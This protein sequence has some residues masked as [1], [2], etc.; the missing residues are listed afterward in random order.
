MQI[1]LCSSQ[2]ASRLDLAAEW[3]SIRRQQ[4]AMMQLEAETWRDMVRDGLLRD[5][6]G[7]GARRAHAPRPR[8]RAAGTWGNLDELWQAALGSTQRGLG[9]PAH[10]GREGPAWLR[11]WM[12]P[13]TVRPTQE[14]IAAATEDM[15]YSAIESPRNDVCPIT[16]QAF[17]LSTPVTRIRSCGHICERVALRRW[18]TFS[19]VCPLCR[20]DI[21]DG[22]N[23]TTP[24]TA[25]ANDTTPAPAHPPQP[26]VPP[27]ISNFTTLPTLGGDEALGIASRLAGEIATQLRQQPP[28]PSGNITVSFDLIGPMHAYSQ[29]STDTDTTQ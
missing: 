3:L 29:G 12:E 18:F 28:D 11:S 19:P 27:A 9:T 26:R 5:P 1:Y 22:P 4:L 7:R 23:D 10:E 14:Q 15:E 2:M 25:P 21:R 6:T 17:E 24:S 8:T 20:G 13:I 16:Q